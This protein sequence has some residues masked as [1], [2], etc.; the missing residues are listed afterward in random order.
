M[1]K[2]MLV[3]P[4]AI[5]NSPLSR[6][7]SQLDEEMRQVLEQTDVGEYTKATLYRDIL[8]KYLNVKHQMQQPT[9]IPIVEQSIENVPHRPISLDLFPKHFQTR[10]QHLLQH[11]EKEPTLG[12]NDRGEVLVRGQPIANSHVVD[13]VNDLVKPKR[14]NNT[15]PKGIDGVVHV[16][17]ESNV[18]MSLIGNKDRFK[19]Q[20]TSFDAMS[21]FPSP[22]TSTPVRSSKRS[23]KAKKPTQRWENFQ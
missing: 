12:W 23:K 11:I 2:F 20:N 5:E 21:L 9:P 7:L 4:T 14:K 1:K 15:S 6:K 17:R 13:I 16:L 3:P 22:L 18:P 10:A 19:D 8:S